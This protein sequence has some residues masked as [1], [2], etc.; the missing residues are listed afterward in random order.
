MDK[1]GDVFISDTGSAR[2][3]EVNAASGI[4]VSVVGSTQGYSG[5][6]GASDR[7]RVSN[8][9]GLFFDTSGNLYIAD[10][11]NGAVRKVSR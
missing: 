3:R 9:L 8:P 6:G 11:G 4:I 10:S 5:D 7:A 2:V 1:A